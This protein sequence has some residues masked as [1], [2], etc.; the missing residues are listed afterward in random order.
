MNVVWFDL[1]GDNIV[2]NIRQRQVLESP[3]IY[4]YYWF[5]FDIT[6]R[7]HVH[8]MLKIESRRIHIITTR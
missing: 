1:G 8:E 4:K 3:H 5:S 7:I 2:R 6:I